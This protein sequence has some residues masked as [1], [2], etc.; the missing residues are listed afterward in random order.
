MQS[1]VDGIK[2]IKSKPKILRFNK[3][4]K[5]SVIKETNKINYSYENRL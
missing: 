1:L 5:D 4:H 2:A 3:H